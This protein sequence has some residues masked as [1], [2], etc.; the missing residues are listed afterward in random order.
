MWGEETG[1]EEVVLVAP[2]DLAW[3]NILLACYRLFSSFLRKDD[4]PTKCTA[5]RAL[6]GIFVSQP[7]LMLQLDRE[8]LIEELMSE[9]AGV[10]LQLES[11]KCWCNIL[12][13]N[14]VFLLFS[15]TIWC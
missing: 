1:S 2:Q 11:L 14:V 8:G 13:V 9:E 3:S 4:S 10:A 5:L 12:E 7:R 15:L 6:G